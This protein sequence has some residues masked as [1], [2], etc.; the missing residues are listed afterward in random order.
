MILKLFAFLAL[1]PVG[2]AVFV[3]Q[4]FG[5]R[6]IAKRRDGDLGI[7]AE[8]MLRRLL[9]FQGAPQLEIKKRVWGAAVDAQTVEISRDDAED[10]SAA[11]LGRAVWLAG[12]AEIAVTT[13]AVLKYWKGARTFGTVAPTFATIIAVF[14]IFSA[15]LHFSTA[16]YLGVILLGLSCVFLLVQYLTLRTAARYGIARLEKARVFHRLDD[17]ESV[18]DAAHAWAWAEMIPQSVQRVWRG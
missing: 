13:P 8:A 6:A 5:R 3:G 1:I 4:M 12:L 16:L 11:A 18:A 2:M 15:R 10:R 14:A 17:E 9:T 7:D